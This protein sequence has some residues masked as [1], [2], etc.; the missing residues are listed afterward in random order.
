MAAVANTGKVW[1]KSNEGYESGKTYPAYICSLSN[2][3]LFNRTAAVAASAG[4][5]AA[6]GAGIGAAVT[7]PSVVGIPA[8]AA[9]GAFIGGMSGLG[10]GVVATMIFDVCKYQ[11]SFISLKQQG[12]SAFSEKL[13]NLDMDP[14]Y[15]CGINHVPMIEPMR[16]VGERQLYDKKALIEWINFKG[17]SPISRKAITVNDIQFAAEGLAYNGKACHEI[18]QDPVALSKFSEEEV[19]ALKAYREDCVKVSSRFYKKE[20]TTIL[21]QAANLQVNPRDSLA[22]LSALI[23][24]MDP[25]ANLDLA[26]IGVEEIPSPDVN[27]E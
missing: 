2:R 7:T 5:G 15:L 19:V 8:G 13:G 14:Q 6:V 17:T 23:D 1:M 3:Q 22:Q 20:T 26:Q 27:I 21:K 9:S 16:I 24:L 11:A 18:L 25:V 4:V 12:G 10:A